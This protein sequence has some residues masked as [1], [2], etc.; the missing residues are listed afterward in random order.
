MI[1]LDEY[2]TLCAQLI[3]ECTCAED[4]EESTDEDNGE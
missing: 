4:G 3:D 1:P 2:C